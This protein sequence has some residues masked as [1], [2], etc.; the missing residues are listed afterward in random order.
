MPG[1]STPTEAFAAINA[2]ADG[3]KLFPALSP[4]QLSVLK[5][6]LPK[7]MPVLPA[8]NIELETISRY[9]QAGASG[10]A[11]EESLYQPG[12]SVSALAQKARTF[13]QA[14]AKK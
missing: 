4:N 10:F 12:D 9:W 5:G 7:R 14:V 11:I 1:F 13:Y 3:L 6:V 8:G 2:G